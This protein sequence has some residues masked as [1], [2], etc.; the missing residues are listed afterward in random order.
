MNT[1]TAPPKKRISSSVV[2]SA[3]EV[4]LQGELELPPG[5]PG[6]V[7]FAH[8]SGSSRHSPRNHFVA[9]MIRS[10]GI[11]TLL[12]DLL[13]PQ[14]E[15]LDEI[16]GALRFDIAL[17]AQRLV[18]VAQWLNVQP[19]TAGLKLGF[20]GASTGGGAA[21]VAAAELGNQIAAV[22]SRGGRPDLAGK[23]LAAVTAPTLL[24]VGGWDEPVIALN[25]E[26][27]AKL[28]GKKDFRIVPGATHLFEEPGKLEQVAQL[29]ADW[30]SQHMGG[31][32]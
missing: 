8:G 5:A 25:H 10:A 9:R 14:E 13:T 21:L 30:F 29:S 32:S 17:L 7:V 28:N 18:E 3:G 20:F 31:E 2:I 24:I 4:E 22:V 27:Y 1:T 15:Q 23:A 26:A 12:L 6:I 16:T 19:D 11:G